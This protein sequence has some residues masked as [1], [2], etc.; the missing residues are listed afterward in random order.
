MKVELVVEA[1]NGIPVGVSTDA[2][3][4]SETMLGP[5]ALAMI[6]VMMTVL[7]VPV[8]ADKA[9]DC[10]WLREYLASKGFIL[11]AR[12][13]SNRAKPATNDGRRLR[14]LKRRWKVERTFAWL[15]SYRRVVTRYE[16][17]VNRYDGFVHLAC[18]FISLGNLL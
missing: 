4:V 18:A 11:L 15:H 5:A 8:L 16:K 14:R 17:S 3:N 10:D 1:S 7:P 13:R 2:A 6:G 12:H 9:Y